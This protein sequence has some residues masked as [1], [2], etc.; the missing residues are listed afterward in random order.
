MT[1]DMEEKQ[2]MD[3]FENKSIEEVQNEYDKNFGD[4]KLC[5]CGHPY[6]R[7]FDTY[8]DMSPASCKYCKCAKFEERFAELVRISDEANE[9]MKNKEKGEKYEIVKDIFGNET[10]ELL[11]ETPTQPEKEW[12][13]EFKKGIPQGLGDEKPY[14]F[15]YKT[16]IGDEIFTITD[17][18]RIGDFIESLL[19]QKDKQKDKE[20]KDKIRLSIN[21]WISLNR[22]GNEYL[23]NEDI[24][25]FKKDLLK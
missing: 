22:K 16:T 4:E 20:W 24:I 5:K 13:E 10:E 3:D 12:K 25:N 21:N 23:S 11:V 6:Y 15:G 2:M 9:I 18:A 1:E 8:D 19:S 7:H 17:W 14:R